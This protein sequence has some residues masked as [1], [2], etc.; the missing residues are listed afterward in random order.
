[1]LVRDTSGGLGGI[2][3]LCAVLN[4]RFPG[5][6][7]ACIIYFLSFGVSF[8]DYAR[9]DNAASYY[10]AASA[11][12]TEREPDL[13]GLHTGGGMSAGAGGVYVGVW[14]GGWGDWFSWEV[15]GKKRER[16]CKGLGVG[17]WK[18]DVGDGPMNHG[19]AL[20]F[21]LDADRIA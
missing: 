19:F 16:G 4:N 9:R 17:G 8:V 10:E 18:L 14:V 15:I 20:S 11:D 5:V 21:F 3:G 1:M 6:E 7:Y 13:W 2:R 12:I